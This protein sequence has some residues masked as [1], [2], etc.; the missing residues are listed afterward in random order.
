[1]QNIKRILLVGEVSG[2]NFNLTEGLKELGVK[3]DFIDLY[4]HIYTNRPQTTT[5]LTFITKLQLKLKKL[6]PYFFIKFFYSHV[7]FVYGGR[8]FLRQ[9]KSP[10]KSIDRINKIFGKKTKKIFIFNGSDARPPLLDGIYINTLAKNKPDFL[11]YLKEQSEITQNCIAAVESIAHTII[12]Q[13]HHNANITKPFINWCI[14]SQA[15][16][17]IYNFKP[18]ILKH[19]NPEKIIIQHSP[20]NRLGKGS[21][22][23]LETINEIISEG[24]NIEYQEIHNKT[25]KEV[26]QNLCNAHILID[27]LYSDIPFAGAA[28]EGMLYNCFTIVGGYQIQETIETIPEH[29]RSCVQHIKPEKNELKS[30]LIKA[31]T[32]NEFRMKEAEKQTNFINIY[33]N[34]KSVAERFLKAINEEAP[35]GWY[36]TQ[37]EPIIYTGCVIQKEYLFYNLKNFVSRF[38]FEATKIKN[39]KLLNKLKELC[40]K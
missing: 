17:E 40:I 16:K 8:K 29:L 12:A 2:Y 27:Q 35:K 26:C 22:L 11:L 33:N 21:D 34:P 32:D 1:M 25:H 23:I 38:G 7:V 36:I 9:K 13:P 24:Y 31:I 10:Q 5:V 39:T 30:I 15:I 18:N 37:Q 20:S 19:K 28:L 6:L 14:I 4:P 3:A